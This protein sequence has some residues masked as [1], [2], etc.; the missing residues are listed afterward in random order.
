[1]GP[2]GG[3]GAVEGGADV[4]GVPGLGRAEHRHPSDARPRVE[5]GRGKSQ[6]LPASAT[7]SIAACPTARWSG[8][9]RLPPGQVA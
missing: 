1:M 8:V 9:L 5:A 2:E 7:A 3:D 4:D 6:R